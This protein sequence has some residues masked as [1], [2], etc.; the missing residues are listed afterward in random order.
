MQEETEAAVALQLLATAAEVGDDDVAP[1]VPAISDAV[2]A[3]ISRHIP[4]HPEPWPQVC[5]QRRITPPFANTTMNCRVTSIKRWTLSGYNWGNFIIHYSSSTRL[6]ESSG[7][8]NTL[9]YR[10]PR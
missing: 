1:H 3:E 10:I 2:Q 5:S 9:D 4:P 7:T 6:T 8:Y